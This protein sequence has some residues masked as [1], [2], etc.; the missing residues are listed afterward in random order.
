MTCGK[1]IAFE[2]IDGSGKSTQARIFADRLK[3]SG[4]PVLQTAEPTSAEI[5]TFIRHLLSGSSPEWNYDWKAMTLL[6]AADRAAH[7]QNVIMPALERGETVICDRY[8]LSTLAYQLTAAVQRGVARPGVHQ[9]MREMFRMFKKPDLT[10]VLRLSVDSAIERINQ[11]YERLEHYENK[12]SMQGADEIYEKAVLTKEF[13][14][15]PNI[16]G[17]VADGTQLE[18]A[19][20]VWRV[21]RGGDDLLQ[22][23]V[24][25]P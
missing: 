1:F 11:R 5:G 12:R 25:E 14:W 17:V 23:G 4:I 18:V 24:K 19:E 16:V 15:L 20:R 8:I 10:I 6:F 13:N 9:W 3:T 22:L 2:G 7:L 21:V